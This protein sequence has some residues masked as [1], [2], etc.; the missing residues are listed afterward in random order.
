[1]VMN[2]IGNAQEIEEAVSKYL[3]QGDTEKAVGI[4]GNN[5]E[6]LLEQEEWQRCRVLLDKFRTDIHDQYPELLYASGCTYLREGKLDKAVQF[7]QKAKV[8]SLRLE[9][10]VIAVKCY[11]ELG[12]V[13]QGRE[14]FQTALNYV[15][16]VDA[17]MQFVT[18]IGVKAKYYVRWA[19]LHLDLG[20]LRK[21]I[22][23]A[24]TA[25][26][27]FLQKNDI[28]G[29][30]DSLWLMAIG[31]RQLGYY[32]Q[33]ASRLEM[34][35]QCHSVGNLSPQ[36]YI[37]LINALAHVNWY[38]GN[39]SEA[40]KQAVQF[41]TVADTH[42]TK[43]H[44]ARILLGNL[45]RA[46]GDYH[47]AQHY[48]DETRQIVQE[49]DFGNYAPWV[50]AQQ[51]WLKALSGEL[52]EARRLIHKAH[53]ETS[54][55]GTLMSFHMFQAGINVL[56]NEFSEAEQQFL[57][58]NEHYTKEGDELSVNVIQL[59]LAYIS[60]KTGRD[61]KVAF[62]YLKKALDWFS[63]RN[64]DYFP[65]WWHPVIVGEICCYAL[66]TNLYPDIVK[67]IL[68]N[69]RDIQGVKLLRNLLNHHEDVNVR[70]RATDAL[71]LMG[72]DLFEELKN[73]E[74]GPAKRVLENLL[75][76][77]LFPEDGFP[78]LKKR[79]VTAQK[80]QTFN[81]QLAAVFGLYM[82]DLKNAEIAEMLSLA[83][84]SV[85]NYITEIYNILEV[86]GDIGS[87]KK[88]KAMLREAA[89]NQGFI[90]KR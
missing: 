63:E 2:E 13:Y 65:H 26:K 60:I 48:Y 31:F 74:E 62:G 68:A 86:P 56:T 9:Q 85:K 30:F 35:R 24:E 8:I 66:I 69:R 78:L 44:Y 25:Y 76:T 40:I 38:A 22:E 54:D 37:N 51:S 89:E 4:L 80:R 42:S 55:S 57:K 72:W 75:I 3:E 45:Y 47:A 29:Q 61:G 67:R 16:E 83:K 84:H 28:S 14:D 87:T 21:G 11:L 59:Y 23:D 73:V 52:T 20:E 79:L 58:C 10:P 82:Q 36:K 81:P 15:H 41:E 18:D 88:R 70:S 27:L 32:H 77:G 64:L 49:L 1:M 53:R 5:I 19:E 34:A 50:D 43:Q 39:L 90:R 7:L 6:Q 17:L 33:A 46:I 71:K 12:H